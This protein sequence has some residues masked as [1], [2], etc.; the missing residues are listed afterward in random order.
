V[1]KT[2]VFRVPLHHLDHEVVLLNCGT[3][4]EVPSFVARACSYIKQHIK[5]E[6]IFRKAGST[7]RQKELKV[8]VQEVFGPAG[9]NLKLII[10][11]TT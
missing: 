11:I 8:S 3:A 1:E 7:S 4:V 9:S 6:G 5:T 2:G 10:F